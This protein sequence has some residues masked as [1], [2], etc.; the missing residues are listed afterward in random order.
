MIPF[1]RQ[2]NSI[3]DKNNTPFVRLPGHP[4]VKMNA[5]HSRLI[6]LFVS[7]REVPYH[8]QPDVTKEP[9]SSQSKKTRLPPCVY[10]Y[11]FVLTLCS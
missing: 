8:T 11:Y 9:P 7:K 5:Q 1:T 3:Q 4:V 6:L 2:K 10:I